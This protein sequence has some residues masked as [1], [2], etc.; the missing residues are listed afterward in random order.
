[1]IEYRGLPENPF[2]FLNQTL[3]LLFVDDDPLL[4]EEI[5]AFFTHAPIYQVFTAQSNSEAVETSVFLIWVSG[6]WAMSYTCLRISAT[7]QDSL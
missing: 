5:T 3:H 7:K 1:M 2:D 4:L 6:T